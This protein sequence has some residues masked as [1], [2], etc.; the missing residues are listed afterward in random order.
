MASNT[1][2]KDNTQG[3]DGVMAEDIISQFETDSEALEDMQ[4]QAGNI[5][6]VD[7][8]WHQVVRTDHECRLL[9]LERVGA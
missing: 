7:N 4:K 5:P 3:L 1:R 9:Y 8:N 2:D 6:A